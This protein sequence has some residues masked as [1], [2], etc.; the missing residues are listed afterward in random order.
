[1][2]TLLI[3]LVGGT[4]P[5]LIRLQVFASIERSNEQVSRGGCT[6]SPVLC[7]GKR[8][9]ITSWSR[10]GQLGVVLGA[11]S[12]EP[13]NAWGR[14]FLVCAEVKFHSQ[15]ILEEIWIQRHTQAEMKH[16]LGSEMTVFPSMLSCPCTESS[17]I[18][19]S[20]D[21]KYF[22]ALKATSSASVVHTGSCWPVPAEK[23][24]AQPGSLPPP[25]NH[26]RSLL[27]L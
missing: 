19:P 6:T 18:H 8:G 27:L 23:K 12:L 11:V 25:L 15:V 20:W 3:H 2:A 14:G 5:I 16:L 10:V 1:M 4:D 24:Q 7:P 17:V 9:L 21:V 13:L 22:T 26:L